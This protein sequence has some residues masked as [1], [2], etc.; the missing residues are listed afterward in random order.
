[1]QGEVARPL[2]LDVSL[3]CRLLRVQEGESLEK[4]RRGRIG[5]LTLSGNRRTAV[6]AAGD[7]E[8]QRE[9]GRSGGKF[10]AVTRELLT[11]P[12]VRPTCTVRHDVS[13]RVLQVDDRRSQ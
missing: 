2:R 4:L 7:K 11:S 12:A 9:N 6:G 1:M 13:F 8:G 5:A 3:C 10:S